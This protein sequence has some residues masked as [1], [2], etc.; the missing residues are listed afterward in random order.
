MGGVDLA[1]WSRRTWMKDKIISQLCYG[2]LRFVAHPKQMT[3]HPGPTKDAS[4]VASEVK[5]GL[6]D[7]WR[8]TRRTKSNQPQRGREKERTVGRMKGREWTCTSIHH[9]CFLFVRFPYH[10]VLFGDLMT[11]R[12]VKVTARWF[13]CWRPEKQAPTHSNH[14]AR[15]PFPTSTSL[16]RFARL[17]IRRTNCPLR[18]VCH[19]QQSPACEPSNGVSWR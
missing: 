5:P 13:C 15:R 4:K 10:L 2:C 1:K 17:Q 18:S 8:P 19:H 9:P 11:K 6:R 12:C 14:C 3:S 16:D 7:G